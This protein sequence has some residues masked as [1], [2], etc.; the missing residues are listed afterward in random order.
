MFFEIQQITWFSIC[1][2]QNPSDCTFLKI[3][4]RCKNFCK[5]AS[6]FSVGLQNYSFQSLSQKL[7]VKNK[8]FIMCAS[9]CVHAR[10]NFTLKQKISKK[11][12]KW[13]TVTSVNLET[14]K[15]WSSWDWILLHIGYQ[16]WS[17]ISYSQPSMVTNFFI[18]WWS[19]SVQN[20]ILH[21]F[22][23]FQSL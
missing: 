16:K 20:L 11:V 6:F 1:E 17:H 18:N 23:S 22:A 15:W 12:Q 5:K 21:T 8:V 7:S 3:F 14:Y 13:I 19:W 9:A 2:S 4:Q 10:A